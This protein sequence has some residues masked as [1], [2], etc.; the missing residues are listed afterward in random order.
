MEDIFSVF[1]LMAFIMVFGSIIISF[2]SRASQ[3]TKNN[4]SPRLTVRAAIVSKRMDV[5][6]HHHNSAGSGMHHSS[7]VTHYFV[8]FEVDSGDRMELKVSGN[9][10]GMLIEGDRGSLEFQGTRY[11]DFARI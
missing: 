9:E 1:F 11:L 3:W 4:N 8:T 7:S 10:Y 5:R 6:R 2:I